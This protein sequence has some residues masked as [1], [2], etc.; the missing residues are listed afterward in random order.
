MAPSPEHDAHVDPSCAVCDTDDAR[1]L[2]STVLASGAVVI[3]CGSH[4]VAHARAS[5]SAKSLTE[6][7]AMLAD[8]REKR[9]R[10]GGH[11]GNV[12]ELAQGLASAFG[13]EQRQR[14]GPGRRYA[15]A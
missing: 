4:A 10:R 9:D 5:W 3:V 12:D 8:R 14:Q 2:S 11:V 6:L 7:R 15:D 13:A 1:T